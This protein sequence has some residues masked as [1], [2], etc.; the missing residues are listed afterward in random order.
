MIISASYKTD[1][2]AFYGR[3][4]MNRLAA[5]YCRM[6]N[7]Y[8]RQFHTVSLRREDVDGIVFWTKNLGPFLPY[9]PAVR[10]SGYPFVVQYTVTGYP[11]ELESSVV[12]W[13]RAVGH[14]RSLASDFG[15]G[16]GVWRY[17][18][19]LLTS[20]TPASF[21]LGQFEQIAEALRGVADEVVVSF[22]QIYAKTRRNLD[23]ASRSL[24]FSWADPS[25]E[26]KGLLVAALAAIARKN[27]LQLTVC[28]QAA[29]AA[30]D[31]ARP[32]RCVDAARLARVAG[33]PIWAR[34][35]GNRPDCECHQSR[36]IGDYDTCPHGCVYCYS[37]QTQALAR[38]RYHAHD[39]GGEFLFPI[40]TPPL[41]APPGR[42][43]LPLFE[44]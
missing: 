29:F 12:P 6:V 11:K 27:G 8:G 4:F 32:A 2:P 18:P 34:V 7:P 20:L 31:G 26:E 21:H 28:S 19:V 1:I 13:E 41:P 42:K 9:L 24:G 23:A 3:W 15:L 25:N 16:V 37:V 17:D 43:Q 35:K 40:D 30:V 5:G 33:R 44:D 10:D 39:P 38:S 36:D 14:L 22:A